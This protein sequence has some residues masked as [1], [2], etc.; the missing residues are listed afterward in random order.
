MK[1][2]KIT[3]FN[4]FFAAVVLVVL[5]AAVFSQ[6][7]QK[8][9]EEIS[10]AS[11]DISVQEFD[12]PFTKIDE[13]GVKRSY[14]KAYVV[15]LRGN[16]GEIGAI[17]VDIFVGDYRIPEY[18]GTKDGI[19]FKIYDDELLEKLEGKPL[20][21]GFQGQKVETLDIQFRPSTLKPFKKLD[22]KQ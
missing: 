12:K 14:K 10:I 18:G 5:L 8:G 7:Q 4:T 20:G 2:R 16:F 3:S 22:K 15:R 17:P 19:Y 21:Y 1:G 6:P 13:K 11:Y 9:I